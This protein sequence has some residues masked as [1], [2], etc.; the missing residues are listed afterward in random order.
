M[1]IAYI[2]LAH[3]SPTQL[4]RL[5]NRLNDGNSLFLIHID[6][7]TPHVIYQK[8]LSSINH[9]EQVYFLK[10]HEVFWGDFSQVFVTLEAIKIL[11]KENIDFDYVRLLTG[12][13]YPI[14]KNSYIQNFLANNYDYSFIENFSLPNQWWL[15]NG[16]PNG[17]LD[18]VNYFHVR[19]FSRLIRTPIKRVFPRK[20]NIFAGS[21]YWLLSKECISYIHE[22]VNSNYDLY[23]FFRGTSNPDEVFFQTILLNSYLKDKIINND[24]TYTDWPS[25]SA[26]PKILGKIDL[27]KMRQSSCLFARKFDINHDSGI[28]DILDRL[29]CEIG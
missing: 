2:I 14:Q 27:E 28:L 25:S 17:G 16:E 20:M 7:K 3:K 9:L 23:D 26:H 29:N 13:D 15:Q 19:F 5:I 24:L 22:F 21:A 18:R 10:R 6:Q 1:K 11:L 12:Q 8:I 4:A